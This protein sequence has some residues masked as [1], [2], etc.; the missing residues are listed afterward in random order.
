MLL[1]IGAYLDIGTYFGDGETAWDD[2]IHKQNRHLY[3]FSYSFLC[4]ALEATFPFRYF[5]KE[6]KQVIL[7]QSMCSLWL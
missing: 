7:S 3:T 1:Y 6:R 2:T 5:S 4:T